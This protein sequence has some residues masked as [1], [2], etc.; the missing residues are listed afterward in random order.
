MTSETAIE[1][2]SGVALW[3][4]I[5]DAIRAGLAAGLADDQGRLPSE[6]ALAERFD[7]N[8]HTVRAALRA[9]ADEGVVEARQGS[10]TYV[11]DRRRLSYPIGART[12]FSAGLEGQA[13]ARLA[14][15]DVVSQPAPADV[16]GMLDLP[17]AAPATRV[18]LLG[19]ADGVAISR[20]T[21]WFDAGRFPGIGDAVARS[22]SVTAALAEAGV[23]DYVRRHTRIE[24]RHASG[25]DLTALNLSPGAIVLVTE[26]LDAGLDGVP[27]HYT[28]TRFAAD[29][30]SLQVA[31][32]G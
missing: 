2:R 29:R 10:G 17:E 18:E 7:V 30:V 19:L 23:A 20:A 32:D 9:L 12:R 28:V 3:R 31:G 26:A 1:R 14:V 15:L 16:S 6:S 4:Q 24:A 13:A 25:G 21:G 22:G 5:A 11:R 27:L 8:R